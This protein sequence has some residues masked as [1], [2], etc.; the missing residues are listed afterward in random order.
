M[1]SVK[2]IITA[3]LTLTMVFQMLAPTTVALAEEINAVS[4]IVAQQADD[5]ENV[6]TINGDTSAGTGGDESGSDD[7]SASESGTTS[8]SAS[9][10]STAGEGATAGQ[11]S[12]DTNE[13]TSDKEDEQDV[14]ATVAAGATITTVAQLKT[15]MAGHGEVEAQDEAVTRITFRDPTALCVIS[16]TSPSL[17]QKATIAVEN[18]TGGAFDASTP[19]GGYAFLG[20]GSDDY[21][22]TGTFDAKSP[23]GS[24]CSIALATSLFNNV[25]LN[26][27]SFM[28]YFVWKGEGS[29]PVVAANVSGAKTLDVTVQI[30][31]PANATVSESTAGITSALF[32]TVTGSLTLSVTYSFSG[33]RK[34]LGATADATGNVGLLANTVENGTFTVQSVTLPSNVASGGTVKTNGG[35]A[36]LLVGE[37]KDGAF[38]SVGTLSN[39][40]TATVQSGNGAPAALWAR[41]GRALAR[42]L[43]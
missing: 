37:A 8:G 38:L 5:V 20:L 26:E 40:P 18:Q 15:A 1:K 7:A 21:P 36:G 9:S 19:Q 24:V 29:E 22:F 41:L 32:G 6:D 43:R 39:V 11:G 42:P 31:D 23:S 17:Y 10:G 28:P 4:G 34:G 27:N 35:N 12:A 14:P 3:C 25:E 2:C 13:D 30:A 16:N 33:T